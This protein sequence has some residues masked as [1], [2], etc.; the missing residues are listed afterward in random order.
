M[1]LSFLS[2]T[3]KLPGPVPR[4]LGRTGPAVL[5]YGFRPF[6][7]LAGSWG[8]PPCWRGLPH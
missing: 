5:S 7:L 2:R 4:G 6:F 3:R 8:W 1:L